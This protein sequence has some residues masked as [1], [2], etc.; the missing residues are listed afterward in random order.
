MNRS[1]APLT[2][3][4]MNKIALLL[5]ES[6]SIKFIIHENQRTFLSTF[7]RFIMWLW[8]SIGANKRG[9]CEIR[10]K[11]S[12]CEIQMRGCARQAQSHRI[13]CNLNESSFIAGVD[14]NRMSNHNIRKSSLIW[15]QSYHVSE[16]W[17]RGFLLCLLCL[18][19][20]FCSAKVCNVE[21]KTPTKFK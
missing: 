1:D 8:K 12:E 9:S 14:N 21:K 3:H 6:E 11:W 20:H 13:Q 7:I 19:C 4:K 17:V 16:Y 5:V 2:R 18:S 10:M 15:F